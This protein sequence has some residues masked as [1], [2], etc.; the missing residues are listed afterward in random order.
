MLEEM[1]KTEKKNQLNLKEKERSFFEE[2][3]KINKKN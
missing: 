3:N 2:K 1:E